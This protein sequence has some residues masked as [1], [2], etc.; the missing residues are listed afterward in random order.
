[1]PKLTCTSNNNN[2]VCYGNGV[3]GCGMC[4]NCMIYELNNY[5]EYDNN[6]YDDDNNWYAV[7]DDWN[8]VDDD[9]DNWY[10]VDDVDG[11]DSMIY[12]YRK[13]EKI[14]CDKVS[15]FSH[16]SHHV[17]INRK[18]ILSSKLLQDSYKI[19]D[20]YFFDSKELL[21]FNIKNRKHYNLICDS[22]EVVHP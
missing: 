7:D 16:Q 2:D 17:R 19:I 1:M 18:L 22:R 20:H 13:R 14:L 9:D 3:H 10:G 6:S 15:G 11:D 4:N 5:I 8:A 12:Y 21:L